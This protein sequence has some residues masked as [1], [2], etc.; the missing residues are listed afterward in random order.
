MSAEHVVLLLDPAGSLA[1]ALCRV[2]AHRGIRVIA[3]G[4]D[5]E[6]AAALSQGLAAERIALTY[7]VAY[8][9]LAPMMVLA[10]RGR[11]RGHWLPV[12]SLWPRMLRYGLPLA[13]AAAPR[14]LNQRLDQLLI[15]GVLPPREGGLYAVAVSWSLLGTLPGLAM[16]SVALSKLAGMKSPRDQRAFIRRAWKSPQFEQLEISR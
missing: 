1:E 3:V 12:P 15:A 8:L 14:L 7:L 11:L 6:Q 2:L 10:V 4:S 5:L 13:G 9:A 16:A